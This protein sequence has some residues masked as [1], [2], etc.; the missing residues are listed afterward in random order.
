MVLIC[1]N[2]QAHFLEH[3]LFLGTE[4]YPDEN[5]YSKFLLEY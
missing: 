2:F 1:S 5:E 3:M 4:K